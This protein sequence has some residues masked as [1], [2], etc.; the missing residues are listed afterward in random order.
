M[1]KKKKEETI[2]EIKVELKEKKFCVGG[3][4][5]YASTAKEA[6]LKAKN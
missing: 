5:I 3:K 6:V 4:T 2:E 1:A